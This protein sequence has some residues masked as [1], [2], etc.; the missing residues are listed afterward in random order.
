V[1]DADTELIRAW[2]QWDERPGL[3]ERV[4]AFEKATKAVAAEIGCSVSL[5]RELVLVLRRYGWSRADCLA[6]VHRALDGHLPVP[7]TNVPE[8][9]A[10]KRRQAKRKDP[11][12]VT[13]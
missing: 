9:L 7:T 5:L 3:I 8:V 6:A 4:D 10:T 12:D 2:E 1:S 13:R 11:A